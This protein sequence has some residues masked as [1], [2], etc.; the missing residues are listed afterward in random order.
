MDDRQLLPHAENKL[1]ESGCGQR[2]VDCI[3]LK[4]KDYVRHNEMSS[5]SD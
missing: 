2:S 1:V 4:T 5:P 3:V